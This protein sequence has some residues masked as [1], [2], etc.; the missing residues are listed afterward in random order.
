M[1]ENLSTKVGV[2]SDTHLSRIDATFAENVNR[3]FSD[4]DA[5]IHAG[6]LTSRAILEIFGDRAVYAVHGNMCGYETRSALPEELEFTIEGY[7]F[8]LY[9]GDGI[10]YDRETELISRFGEVDCIIFGHTHRPLVQKF[11]SVLLVNPG[12]FRSTGRYGGSGTYAVMTL[13]A[14][15]LSAAIHTLPPE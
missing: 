3:A 9:H 8:G 11:G 2:L 15:G 4:C 1:L 13:D 6:D 10:G 12:T 14:T 7:R 5:V